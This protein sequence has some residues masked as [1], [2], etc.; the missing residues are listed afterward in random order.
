MRVLQLK[1][2]SQSADQRTLQNSRSP[3]PSTTAFCQMFRP[4]AKSNTHM[5]MSP[6]NFALSTHMSPSLPFASLYPRRCTLQPDALALVHRRRPDLNN[7]CRGL[8]HLHTRTKSLPYC[9]TKMTSYSITPGQA[10]ATLPY[11]T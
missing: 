5:S 1:L 6:Y 4:M 11:G 10:G 7:L 2:I 9:T 8:G 3:L